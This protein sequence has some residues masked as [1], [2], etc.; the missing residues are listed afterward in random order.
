MS[1]EVGKY[2]RIILP[3]EPLEKYGVKE[4]FRLIVMDFMEQIP[5]SCE[6]I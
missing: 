3:K 4:G 2:G 5:P 6:K 1:V